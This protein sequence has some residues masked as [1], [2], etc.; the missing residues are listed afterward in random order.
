MTF[1]PAQWI[2]PHIQSIDPY[3]PIYPF[4]VVAARLGRPAESIIK[5]DANENPYGPLPQVH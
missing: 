1:T 5:L 3:Q 4:E 2:R